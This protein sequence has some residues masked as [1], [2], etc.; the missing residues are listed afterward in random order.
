V[1]PVWMSDDGVTWK[2]ASIDYSIRFMY[3]AVY[4]SGVSRF[5]GFDLNSTPYYS[6]HK[7][8]EGAAAIANKLQADYWKFSSL[9]SPPYNTTITITVNQEIGTGYNP[10]PY[11]PQS[12]DIIMFR[13]TNL[14]VPS[15][16]FILGGYMLT[17]FND[18]FSGGS[19]GS[20]S[21]GGGISITDVSANAAQRT[22]SITI[23]GGTTLNV[24]ALPMIEVVVMRFAR[25]IS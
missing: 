16:T 20:V 12:G 4:L 3:S 7:S 1:H 5:A 14:Q 6:E 15:A 19:I 13:N 18:S 10:D 9:S 2:P 22:L 8:A 25:T 11:T 21:S 17:T 24:L 23:S